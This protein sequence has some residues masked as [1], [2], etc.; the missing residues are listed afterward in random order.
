MTK[1]ENNLNSLNEQIK[2]KEQETGG[3]A[4]F[5]NKIASDDNASASQK[6][7]ARRAY[8][9]LEG[10]SSDKPSWYDSYVH[11]DSETDATSL[12]NFYKTLPYYDQFEEIRRDNSLSI[13]RVSLEQIAIAMLDADYSSHI[14]DHARHFD[15]SENLAWGV[16]DDPNASLMSEK[17]IWDKAVAQDSS[18]AAYKN[19][20]YD[21]SQ[22]DNSFYEQ[23]GHYLNLIDPKIASYGYALN[24]GEKE[25]GNTEAFDVDD[26]DGTY[27]V[28]DFKAALT[29]YYDDLAKPDQVKAAQQQVKAAK[30][31]LQEAIEQS[32]KTNKANNST[33]SNSTSQ[34]D[35]NSNS[36]YTDSEESDSDSN[37][38]SL[39]NSSDLS[40]SDS[41]SSDSYAT[42]RFY[43]KHKSGNGLINSLE[44]YIYVI[45]SGRTNLWYRAQFNYKI[46][47]NGQRYDQR[48]LVNGIYRIRVTSMRFYQLR[49]HASWRHD[50]LIVA[51]TDAAINH[52]LY[53]PDQVKWLKSFN[54]RPHSHRS[55]RSISF[56]IYVSVHGHHYQIL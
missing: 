37:S 52:H 18:L 33:S 35:K 23:V 5:F 46:T 48:H 36:D 47:K 4:G 11:L 29:A 17:K 28:A 51:K 53:Y 39:D 13:P 7:D 14:L 19:N 26:S 32:K 54:V 41:D 40:D 1:A 9:L 31:D 12:E 30:E 6:E 15:S 3:A 43:M 45:S 2:N 22:A 27:T 44:R 21:L 8:A 55:A 38:D 16:P 24:T 25:Y 50:R 42:N 20:A 34:K 49:S 56:T 10:Q